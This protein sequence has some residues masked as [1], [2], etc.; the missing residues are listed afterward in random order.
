MVDVFYISRIGNYEGSGPIV[1]FSPVPPNKFS[2]S[3]LIQANTPSIIL[4][5]M[6]ATAD[7]RPAIIL[8]LND[9]C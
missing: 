2:D 9:L 1:V 7:Y 5:L 6:H 3:I 4:Y 8:M